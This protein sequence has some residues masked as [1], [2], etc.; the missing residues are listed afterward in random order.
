MGDDSKTPDRAQESGFLVAP[1]GVEFTITTYVRSD[2]TDL[3]MVN[4]RDGL[5]LLPL[6]EMRDDAFALVAGWNDGKVPLGATDWRFMTRAEIAEHR[7]V[8]EIDVGRNGCALIQPEHRQLLSCVGR[9]RPSLHLDRLTRSFDDGAKFDESA[10]AGALDDAPM[11][12]SGRGVNQIVAQ[13][14]RPRRCGPRL[15]LPAL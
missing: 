10:V 13:R 14:P 5:T 11:M 2:S 7:A 4:V 3:E 6:A 12:R 8:E 1:E 9:K 15:H